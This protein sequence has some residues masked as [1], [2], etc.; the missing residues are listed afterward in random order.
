MSTVPLISH[1]RNTRSEK[2]ARG[3]TTIGIRG[4][5]LFLLMGHTI[6]SA[7]G[8]LTLV[9]AFEVASVKRN[10]SGR[11]GGSIRVPPAP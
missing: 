2:L 4:V 8:P 1:R 3:Q 11:P 9:P 7:Q 5:L 6:A 10:I